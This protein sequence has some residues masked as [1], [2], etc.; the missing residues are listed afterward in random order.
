MNLS[1]PKSPAWPIIYQV[2]LLATTTICCLVLYSSG[3]VPKD[4]VLMGANAVVTYLVYL[5]KQLMT[6]GTN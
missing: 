4:A 5:I 3:L 1:D 2:A 6:D